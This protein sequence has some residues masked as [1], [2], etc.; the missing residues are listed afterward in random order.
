MEKWMTFEICRLAPAMASVV[1]LGML[2]LQP[3]AATA[4]VIY[5][6][7]GGED[8]KYP[9]GGVVTDSRGALYGLTEYGGTYDSGTAFKLSPP[10]APATAWTKTTL[11]SFGGVPG[12]VIR[13]GGLVIDSAGALYGTTAAGGTFNFGFVFKLTPPIPPA[14]SWTRTVIHNFKG[15]DDGRDP[16]SGLVFD[17]SGTLYGTTRG[18]G[19]ENKGVIYKLSPSTCAGPPGYEESVIYTFK[20]GSDG[21]YPQVGVAIDKTGALYGGTGAA[22]FKLTP[23]AAPST[24]WTET[25]L[26]SIPG[27]LVTRL[28]TDS[29][30]ALYG[31]APYEYG[32]LV[33]K[34]EPPAPPATIWRYT[35][36]LYVFAGVESL[37]LDSA[38]G[39]LYGETPYNNAGLQWY[40]SIVKL[41]PSASSSSKWSYSAIQWFDSPG[42]GAI[43]VGGLLIGANGVLYGTTKYTYIGD[44]AYNTWGFGVVFQIK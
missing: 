8:G 2:L 15:G 39:A 42:E 9:T 22:V 29:R 38:N 41:E 43:P 33:F 31:A 17:N 40:D 14:T 37:V 30:G 23:P 12:E 32:S 35:F 11:Y 21:G 18:G 7:K 4:S 25:I 34:L 6:F 26:H 10:V 13:R 24:V 36:L 27:Q 19:T 1:A 20:G 44:G 3:A 5:V 16:N 28:A